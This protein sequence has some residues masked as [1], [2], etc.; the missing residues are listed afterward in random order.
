MTWCAWNWTNPRHSRRRKERIF[1]AS[2]VLV[3]VF[4]L[5]DLR[6]NNPSA[7]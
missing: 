7:W 5:V 4:D 3:L 6:I 1:R 2:F